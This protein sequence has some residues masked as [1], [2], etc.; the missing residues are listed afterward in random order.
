MS[1]K[2]DYQVSCAEVDAL[3]DMAMAQ[4]GVWGSRMTGAGFGGCIVSLVQP[5]KLESVQV[6][7]CGLGLF[8]V[9]KGDLGGL[10][11]WEWCGLLYPHLSSHSCICTGVSC[12]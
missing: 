11:L 4:E 8:A 7:V 5:D 3:V 12:I 2:D 1:L 6:C 9:G 10:G